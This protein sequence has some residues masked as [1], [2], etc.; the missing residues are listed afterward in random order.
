[1]EPTVKKEDGRYVI[2]MEEVTAAYRKVRSNKRAGA[3]R[4]AVQIVE[5]DDKWQLFSGVG[6]M[7]EELFY[8]WLVIDLDI[9]GF[10]DNIDH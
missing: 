3:K 2:S 7:Q 9:K 5:P 10:F 1:M 6:A 4:V 8:E